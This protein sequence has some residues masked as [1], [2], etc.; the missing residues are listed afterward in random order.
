M[1]CPSGTLGKDLGSLPQVVTLIKPAHGY[2]SEGPWHLQQPNLRLPDSATACGA[3]CSRGRAD[4]P[5]W[6]PRRGPEALGELPGFL[7]ALEV[8]Q[9]VGVWAPWAVCRERWWWWWESWGSS[10]SQMCSVLFP[11]ST[12]PAAQSLLGRITTD[13]RV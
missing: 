2:H 7:A 13:F 10:R 5:S 1:V 8:V 11:L 3:P 6:G 4:R 12:R 9:A